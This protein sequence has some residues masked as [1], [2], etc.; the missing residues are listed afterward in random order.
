MVRTVMYASI[1]HAIHVSYQCLCDVHGCT[2]MHMTLFGAAK[3]THTCFLPSYEEALCDFE[4]AINLQQTL[5]SPHVCAGLIHMLHLRNL[6]RAVRYFSGAIMVDPTFVRAYLCRAEAYKK[7]E[8]VRFE[9]CNST[10]VYL[11]HCLHPL[12][13]QYSKAIL[14]YTRALHFEPNNP[15]HFLLKVS[16]SLCVFL[17]NCI[18]YCNV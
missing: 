10:C 13:M 3:H 16:P 11:I 12:Y 15:R 5:P 8:K 18:I 14:D 2:I 9:C 4:A 17:C 1:V 7:D 6:P